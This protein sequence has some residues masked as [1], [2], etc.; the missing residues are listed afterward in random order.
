MAKW[1]NDLVIDTALNYE[2][3]NVTQLAICS[4]QPADYNA[5]V[6]TYKL[7]IKTG[8]TSGSFTGPADG[9][10]SGRKL[11]MNLQSG[12]AVD[13]GGTATHVAWCTGSVLL[14]VTTCTSQVLTAGNTITF[15][16]HKHEITDL[17]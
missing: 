11:T 12:V 4:Q 17:A 5:A 13:S 7:G 16:A 10:V 1:L 8:L 14:F 3:N 2:K 6:S 15:P 9:D